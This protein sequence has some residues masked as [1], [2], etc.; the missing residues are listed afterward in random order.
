MWLVMY[1][2]GRAVRAAASR[3]GGISS[4]RS[5]ADKA[6]ADAF[7]QECRDEGLRASE[8]SKV[9]RTRRT[10]SGPEGAPT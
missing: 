7:A 3:N 8:P 1:G 5:F 4:V 9:D 10:A 6:S 2:R